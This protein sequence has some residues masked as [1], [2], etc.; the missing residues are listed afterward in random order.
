MAIEPESYFIL[1]EYGTLFSPG[2]QVALLAS[3]MWLRAA[4]GAEAEA[5][6]DVPPMSCIRWQGSGRGAPLQGFQVRSEQ[7][8]RKD[9]R[10]FLRLGLILWFVQA[11]VLAIAASLLMFSP[12]AWVD[13]L[14]RV[15]LVRN[16]M[17]NPLEMI[18][19][20]AFG[21]LCL[22]VGVSGVMESGDSSFDTVWGGYLPLFI[23]ACLALL[24]VRGLFRPWWLFR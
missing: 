22:L 17:A 9:T 18:V 24:F 4:R 23:G 2:C 21:T 5:V 13:H 16:F 10:L 3:Q 14:E 6:R 1:H 19:I 20:E 7:R 11:L 15:R 8:N 12:A